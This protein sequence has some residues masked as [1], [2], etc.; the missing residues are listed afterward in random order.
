ME[1]E[2]KILRIKEIMDC[3][4]LDQKDFAMATKIDPGNV[5]KI[6]NGKIACGDG[7]LNKIQL[8]FP[9]LNPSWIHKG[10]GPMFKEK[11]P[12]VMQNNVNGDNNYHNHDS[13]INN[14]NMPVKM[15][16]CNRACEN[17]CDMAEKCPDCGRKTGELIL[18]N[19][20]RKPVIPTEW[21]YRPNIDIFKEVM[22]NLDKVSR[23]MF[24]VLDCPIDVWLTVRDDSLAPRA[25]RGDS[26]GLAQ[27]P[28]GQED[29]IW[30]KFH[31]IDTKTNGLIVRKLYP[32]ENGYR[33]VS[34]NEDY[35]D[36]IV[37]FENIISV[38]RVVYVVRKAL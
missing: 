8:A 5:S 15:R 14:P 6:I 4:N 24:I 37:K 35:P 19:E 22:Q 18:V 36:F 30:G 10:E 7:V 27:Y 34:P 29:P 2:C 26:L 23:S 9:N 1:K 32:A 3:Y 12:A 38:S 25:Y 28:P 31:A 11:T 17:C 16:G 21:A 13:C 33:C 20:V